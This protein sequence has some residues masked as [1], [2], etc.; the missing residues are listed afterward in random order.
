MSRA[1][2]ANKRD[3][4]RPDNATGIRRIGKYLRREV[5]GEAKRL[6]FQAKLIGVIDPAFRRELV[7]FHVMEPLNHL[8]GFEDVSGPGEV[9]QV[10]EAQILENLKAA[11]RVAGIA[12]R[13]SLKLMRRDMREHVCRFVEKAQLLRVLDP[14]FE[15]E[16]RLLG[17]RRALDTIA[18]WHAL[19]A[20]RQEKA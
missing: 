1:G 3:A 17:F 10:A 19:G 6:A 2:L 13:R 4:E 14:R 11:Q 20:A 5:R 12:A 8:L 7:R 15:E 18:R 16:V 9:N